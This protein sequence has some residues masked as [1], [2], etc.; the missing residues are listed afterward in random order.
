[1]P[2]DLLNLTRRWYAT[3]T[4]N[5][6][7]FLKEVSKDVFINGKNLNPESIDLL[8]DCQ[9]INGKIASMDNFYAALRVYKMRHKNMDIL[10]LSEIDTLKETLSEFFKCY[11][12]ILDKKSCEEVKKF[13][14]SKDPINLMYHGNLA[15]PEAKVY[16]ETYEE[17]LRKEYETNTIPLAQ[18]SSS[19]NMFV[20]EEDKNNLIN[21]NNNNIIYREDIEHTESFYIRKY[22]SKFNKVCMEKGYIFDN[23]KDRDTAFV[24]CILK[25]FHNNDAETIDYA[26][27][28]VEIRKDFWSFIELNDIEQILS[29]E[30]GKIINNV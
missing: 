22:K 28:L 11:K 19:C 25:K 3:D 10:S 8:Y 7:K 27:S 24:N 14:Y 2:I 26:K 12:T 30:F 5:S 18:Q 9:T 23:Y 13:L 4:K 1:M 15:F 6:I 29:T 21:K 16:T 20:I 17:E